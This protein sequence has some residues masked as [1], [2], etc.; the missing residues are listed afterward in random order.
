MVQQ[1]KDFQF[2]SHL[3][4]TGIEQVLTW[5]PKSKAQLRQDLLAL[6][7]NGFHKKGYFV[8][9]GATDGIHWS[10][11]HLLE[12]EFEWKGIVGEPA[13]KYHND[14]RNNRSCYVETDCV[15][16][17]T[18]QTLRFNE[19]KVGY[20]S[21]IEQFSNHDNHHTHRKDGR[22]YPVSSISLMDLLGK[23]NAPSH[24]D[25]LSID[26]E[27]SEF[28]ILSAF[29]F[30]RYSFSLITCEHNYTDNRE[31]IHGL[32]SKHG[33]TRIMEDV[34]QFDDWYILQK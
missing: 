21:T 17:H 19:T 5:L 2:V 29:D 23:Y 7:Y 24:I 18:G 30:T 6:F 9:F 15:W 12:H 34:S 4:G 25:Y 3:K 26:T 10:N 20:Y 13:R 33:Y 28:E 22:R 8:E 16:S 14:L 1:S 11:T 32:L 27:G 31:K